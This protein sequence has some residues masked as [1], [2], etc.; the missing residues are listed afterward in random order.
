MISAAEVTF[1]PQVSII[2][3]DTSLADKTFVLIMVDPDAPTPQNRSLSE[4]RH[5][6]SGSMT[7]SGSLASGATLTNTT[8]AVSDYITPGPPAGSDP[9]R[10]TLM[11][12]VEPSD[13]TTATHSFVNA[14]VAPLNFNVS[15]FAQ[16]VGL[17]S[18]VAGTYFLTGPESSSSASA[19]STS[20]GSASPTSTSPS[21]GFVNVPATWM[22][23]SAVLASL[24]AMVF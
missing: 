20:P 11:L 5:F 12:F 22:S 19:S 3:N 9:H 7:L 21:S 6:I 10:Y 15:T 16:E 14:S 2:S 13:F 23:L 24:A 4:V 18:P 17:G 1:A 8:P